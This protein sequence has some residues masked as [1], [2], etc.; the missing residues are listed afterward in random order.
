MYTIYVGIHLKLELYSS[1]LKLQ[2]TF[3]V[4][5]AVLLN[6]VDT[7][8]LLKKVYLRWKINRNT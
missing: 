2:S 8:F 3:G 6:E 5:L 7:L 1:K 4:K